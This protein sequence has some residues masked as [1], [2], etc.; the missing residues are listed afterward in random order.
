M[1]KL[2]LGVVIIIPPACCAPSSSSFE[3][4]AYLIITIARLSRHGFPYAPM[5]PPIFTFSFLTFKKLTCR[6][7]NRVRGPMISGF[8]FRVRCGFLREIRAPRRTTKH[9]NSYERG[10]SKKQVALQFRPSVL[11]MAERDRKRAYA[12]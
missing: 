10:T 3:S 1:L 2:L 9:R 5:H 4:A 8:I 7:R 11:F 12:D 6:R